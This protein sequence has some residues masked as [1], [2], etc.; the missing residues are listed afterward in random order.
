MKILNSIM[1]TFIKIVFLLM[2]FMLPNLKVS[3]QCEDKIKYD[4]VVNIT[5]QDDKYVYFD[6]DIT[7]T[8]INMDNKKYIVN[9]TFYFMKTSTSYIQKYVNCK[10][11]VAGYPGGEDTY[12]G[13]GK[14][15]Q[16]NWKQVA[17]KTVVIEE[18]KETK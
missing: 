3:A 4:I 14:M 2:I 11:L 1:L 16:D 15:T 17:F 9:S 6:F 13:N 7:F 12:Y 8:A 18:C 5:S 10:V